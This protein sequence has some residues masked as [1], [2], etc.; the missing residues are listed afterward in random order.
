M[1]EQGSIAKITPPNLSGIQSR[2]RLFRLLDEGLE[3]PDE[4]IDRIR[5][6]VGYDTPQHFFIQFK[7]NTGKSPREYRLS[8]F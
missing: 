2:K 4:S 5:E 6:I 7:K 3:K 8:V 1:T